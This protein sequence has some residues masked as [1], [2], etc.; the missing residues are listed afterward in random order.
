MTE[1]RHVRIEYRV[2]DD[3]NLD[4]L[5][6]SIGEFV[7]GMRAH[8]QAT[9]YTSYRDAKD[10]RH[11]VHVGHFRPDAAASLQTQPF[12]QSF[13]AKLRESCASGPDVTNLTPVAST[14]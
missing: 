4:Q 14:R 8:D 11:F 3:I 7:A 5:A 10:P 13:T 2:R 9:D 6:A 12:F 1:Q